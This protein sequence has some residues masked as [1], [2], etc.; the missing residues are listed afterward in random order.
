MVDKVAL[1]HS[2]E[3]WIKMRRAIYNVLFS[4][5]M[6]KDVCLDLLTES[7]GGL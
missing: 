5:A 3:N 1:R 2:Q 7:Q 4:V 6:D